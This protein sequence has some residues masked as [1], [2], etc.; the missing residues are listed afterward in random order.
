MVT[1]SFFYLMFVRLQVP[2]VFRFL[3][4]TEKPRK[5]YSILEILSR[6][7][8]TEIQT[9]NN[10]KIEFYALFLSIFSLIAKF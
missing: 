6:D 1:F 3:C 7:S 5:L 2:D 4:E 10:K 8:N 9:Q